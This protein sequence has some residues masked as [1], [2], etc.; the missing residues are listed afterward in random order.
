MSTD[1]HTTRVPQWLWHLANFV[2]VSQVDPHHVNVANEQT[3]SLQRWHEKTHR[4]S[5]SPH[6][7]L[8][9]RTLLVVQRGDVGQLDAAM[10]ASQVAM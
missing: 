10:H 1:A 9:Q 3:Q 7:T 6:D 8:W 5:Q 4:E 2:Q